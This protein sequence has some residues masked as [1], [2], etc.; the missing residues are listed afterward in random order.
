MFVGGE[1]EFVDFGEWTQFRQTKPKVPCTR[2]LARAMQYSN[3]QKFQ[4]RQN[5]L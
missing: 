4:F 2:S 5:I 3:S 1:G